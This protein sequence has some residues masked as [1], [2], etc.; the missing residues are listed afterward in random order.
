MQKSFSLLVLFSA[1]VIGA[2][3]QQASVR[4]TQYNLEKSGLAIQGHDPVAYF[5]SNQ[6]IEGKEDITMVHNGVTYRFANALNRETFK[7]NP[8]KYEP[9]YGGW[10]AYAMGAAGKKVEIDPE[11]FKIVDGKLFLFYNALFNNTL[12]KWNENEANLKT[13]ADKN[14]KKF[15]Q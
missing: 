1:L 4:K 8:A 9:Q 5:I 13:T 3:A 10:C 7:A 12:P 11:T 15:V 6:A 2:S 14:W